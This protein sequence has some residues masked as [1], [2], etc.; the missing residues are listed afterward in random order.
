MKKSE[1]LIVLDACQQLT[2]LYQ[3]D[4]AEVGETLKAPELSLYRSDLTG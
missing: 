2:T 1:H 3:D 4:G